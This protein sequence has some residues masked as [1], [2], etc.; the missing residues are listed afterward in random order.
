VV[1]CASEDRRDEEESLV[2][3]AP[4]IFR[5]SEPADGTLVWRA[6]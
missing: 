5:H 4:D 1:V 3:P 6:S 2:H